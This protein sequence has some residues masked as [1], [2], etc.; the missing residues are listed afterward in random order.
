MAINNIQGGAKTGLGAALVVDGQQFPAAWLPSAINFTRN[1]IDVSHAQT[2]DFRAAIV[3]E[4]A[5]ELTVTGQFY[6]DPKLEALVDLMKSTGANQD[7]EIYII[8]PKTSDAQ[9]VTTEPM[10]LYLSVGKLGIGTIALDIEDTMKA[11]FTVAGGIQSPII[12]HQQVVASNEP[13]STS[14]ITSNLSGTLAGDVVATIT[15]SGVSHGPTIFFELGGTDAA[16]FTLEGKFIKAKA[17]GGGGAGSKSLTVSCAG[18]RAW[19]D[20]TTG[21][22]L[23]GEAIAFTLS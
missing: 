14:I 3:E 12:E 2:E 8:V 13:V 18:Y 7:R 21:E 4:L 23:T 17:D 9:G 6:F 22:H 19:N 5:E 1:T 16:D 15:A 11:D 20:G 10:F